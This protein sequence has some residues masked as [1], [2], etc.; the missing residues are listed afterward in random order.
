MIKMKTLLI[1]QISK[2]NILQII[3]NF[4]II[5]KI[6]IKLKLKQQKRQRQKKLYNQIHIYLKQHVHMIEEKKEKF[7]KNQIKKNLKIQNILNQK[8]QIHFAIKNM[9][10]Q[11]IFTKK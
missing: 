4:K 6:M 3:R 5:Q 2:L 10:K 8:E 11:H 7:M 9:I 1:N